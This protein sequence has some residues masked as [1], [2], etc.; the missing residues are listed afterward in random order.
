MSLYYL[1][2]AYYFCFAHFY[3]TATH[4]L[5][6]YK[7]YLHGSRFCVLENKYTLKCI[8]LFGKPC[9]QLITK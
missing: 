4:N 6:S 9:K 7:L 8:D 5:Y 1:H 3:F 2:C